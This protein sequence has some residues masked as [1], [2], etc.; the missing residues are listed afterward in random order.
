MNYSESV[1]YIHSF[2]RL[3]KTGDHR[4]ILTLLHALGDPQK[5]GHYIHITGTNGKGSTANAIA[6]VLEA[7]GLKV[8][9]F[10]SPFIMRFNERMMIDHKPIPDDELVQA[11]AVARA[12][13]DDLRTAQPDFNV[14]EFEFVTALAFW[15]FRQRRVD[16]AVI[17]VGIGGDTD[18]T[19]V[20]TPVVSVL[21]EVA[22]DHQKLLGNTIAAI[23][24]HKAG[25]IK[26][27]VPVVTGD[28]VPEAA[29]VVA[30][31]TQSTGSQWFRFGRDF[32]VPKAKLHGWGQR[33]AYQDEDGSLADLT[34]P[35]VGD[36]Q[37]RNMAIAI[38]TAK[39]Y[40]QVTDWP[41]TARDIRQGLAASRWPARLEKISDSPF[42]VLD[43]AHNPDGIKGLVVA[44]HELFSGPV[45]VIAGI[46]A[47]KDYASMADML[48]RAFAT[49][50]L[51][52]VPGTPRA[53][54]EA[55]YQRLHEGQLKNSW[56]AALAAS[57][58][59][60]PDQP[61]VI[62]GSLY[63]AAAARQTLLEGK[64]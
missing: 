27:G 56:Q 28:L 15:Y 54:P 2:P 45:T 43:G 16:V 24:T 4:R 63:L 23:A 17:E 40:A 29:A 5:E 32:T 25:I 48:T 6:H 37:Q 11:V 46:L 47:D 33:L 44:L 12:A 34:V 64:L 13:L 26:P 22:L 57:L 3:A 30:A 7:G 35:L 62:T 50:Y 8:G 61:I 53:L 9:L 19:N 1:A 10:T 36:Y 14:T 58:D 59:A 39:I 18:S 49:V 52:P 51:V 60:D 20:I 21:T 42:I 38:K 31:K 41:L 55:G